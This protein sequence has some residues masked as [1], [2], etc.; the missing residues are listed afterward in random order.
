MIHTFIVHHEP[1]ISHDVHVTMVGFQT[2]EI[3]L[4]LMHNRT[5]QLLDDLLGEHLVWWMQ[6]SAAVLAAFLFT[7]TKHLSKENLRKEGFTLEHGSRSLSQLICT[8]RGRNTWAHHPASVY[9]FLMPAH[10]MQL[11]TFYMDPL[12][13][14]I[15]YGN[16]QRYGQMLVSYENAQMLYPRWL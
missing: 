12:T 5:I 4:S 1:G 15:E 13:Y 9:S 16:S 3:F 11:S 10:G 7:M 2:E 8:Q 14:L 6:N